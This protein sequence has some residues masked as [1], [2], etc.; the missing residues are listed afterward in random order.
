MDKLHKVSHQLVYDC[1][2]IVLEDLNVRGMVKNHKLAKHISDAG[3]GTFVRLLEYKGVTR[4]MS[5][6]KFIDAMS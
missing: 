5:F 2:I 4:T 1:D 3:W 6:K